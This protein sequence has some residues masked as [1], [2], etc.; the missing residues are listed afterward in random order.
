MSYCESAVVNTYCCMYKD[1][2][3]LNLEWLTLL[4]WRKD[5]LR[6]IL[7][8][9]S[10]VHEIW[11]QLGSP[12]KFRGPFYKSNISTN[13]DPS[14]VSVTILIHQTSSRASGPHFL[15]SL[16]STPWLSK[17]P[18]AWHIVLCITICQGEVK[19]GTSKNYWNA[20]NQTEWAF[21]YH[22]IPARK[23]HKAASW[24]W[25]AC[26]HWA[27]PRFASYSTSQADGVQLNSR[28]RIFGRLRLLHR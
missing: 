22:A 2:F 8:S 16:D 6:F 26:L 15:V 20:L 27:H 4:G 21:Y 12:I 3:G 9:I 19:E 11:K 18:F 13:M 17:R 23:G 7:S 24:V 10:K 1:M 5:A 25:L 14:H 28:C